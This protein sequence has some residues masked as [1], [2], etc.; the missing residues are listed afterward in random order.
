MKV[1]IDKNKLAQIY[2]AGQHAY[3][4]N[5][6]SAGSAEIHAAHLEG[7]MAVQLETMR[8]V[9]MRIPKATGVR[10]PNDHIRRIQKEFADY[11]AG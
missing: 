5:T 9:V 7:L 10:E 3:L 8:R 2:S 4:R 1:P 11:A 6:K